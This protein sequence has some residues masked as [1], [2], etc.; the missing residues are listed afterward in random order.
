MDTN[1]NTPTQKKKKNKKEKKGIIFMIVLL[2]LLFFWMIKDKFKKKDELTPITP[3]EFKEVVVYVYNTDSLPH[4]L[5]V[6]DE[7]RNPDDYNVNFYDFPLVKFEDLSTEDNSYLFEMNYFI[8]PVSG[9]DDALNFISKVSRHFKSFFES[10]KVKFLYTDSSG[11][12]F[13]FDFS[14]YPF[15]FSFDAEYNTICF[16]L[17]NGL[18]GNKID[19]NKGDVLHKITL[20]TFL[21]KI[22]NDKVYFYHVYK[23]FVQSN[24][25]VYPV[26][27]FVF[28]NNRVASKF[29]DL[30]TLVYGTYKN[31]YN[32]PF[33]QALKEFKI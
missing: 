20:N 2:L 12:E 19:S 17:K 22:E 7:S 29:Y 24:G 26:A 21:C 25:F 9:N 32:S 8:P 5:S 23:D 30:F 27:K 6:S 13:S 16:D 3:Q 15:V 14:D 31:G 33:F 1:N 10:F 28:K 18:N 4:F 11:S